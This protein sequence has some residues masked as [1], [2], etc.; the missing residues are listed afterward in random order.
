MFVITKK[1][2][3][4]ILAIKI[5]EVELDPDLN[6]GDKNIIIRFYRKKIKAINPKAKF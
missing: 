5:N 3:I 4:A 6:V 2:Q 1:N